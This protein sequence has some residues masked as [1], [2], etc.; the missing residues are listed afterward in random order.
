[1]EQNVLGTV[2]T[3]TGARMFGFVFGNGPSLN[4]PSK[5]QQ[6]LAVPIEPPRAAPSM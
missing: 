3:I 1:M 6:W 5:T 2:G 4:S